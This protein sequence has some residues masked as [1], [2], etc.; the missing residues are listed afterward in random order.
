MSSTRSKIDIYG[1]PEETVTGL[2]ERMRLENYGFLR[3]APPRPPAG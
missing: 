2:L 1:V 3:S